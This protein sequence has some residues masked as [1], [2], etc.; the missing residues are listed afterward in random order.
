MPISEES[1]NELPKSS[2]ELK[3]VVFLREKGHLLKQASTPGQ[4]HHYH[5]PQ[6]AQDGQ[7]TW[8]LQ[9][10]PD[11][12]LDVTNVKARQESPLVSYFCLCSMPQPSF[13]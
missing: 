7:P 8:G 13:W 11:T 3:T 5:S 10:G 9:K 4:G 6:G 2:I 12:G 1:I